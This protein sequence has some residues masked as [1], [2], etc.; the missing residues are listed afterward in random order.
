MNVNDVCLKVYNDV[1]NFD[2]MFVL[3]GHGISSIFIYDKLLNKKYL[4]IYQKLYY[5]GETNK[6]SKKYNYF[7]H[8]GVEDFS[9][10]HS[11]SK[12][13]YIK[14]YPLTRT[15]MVK[16]NNEEDEKAFGVVTI[17]IKII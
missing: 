10:K 8:E 7:Y 1:K 9:H 13:K 6:N 12:G 4:S 15:I 3:I 11:T 2:G 14:Y 17:R 16:F 5:F